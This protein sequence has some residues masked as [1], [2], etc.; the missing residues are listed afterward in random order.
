MKLD[1]AEER[2]KTY[3]EFEIPS[4]AERE[5]FGPGDHVKLIFLAEEEPSPVTVRGV[6]AHPT[7]ERMWV[8]VSARVGGR[9]EGTLSNKP[10]FIP[11]TYGDPVAFGPEH[12]IE[13][14]R[15]DS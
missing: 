9:Y 12:I 2:A 15:L 5:S 8:R 4:R 13:G 6:V 11:L 14:R 10:A 1:N 3:P 7:G